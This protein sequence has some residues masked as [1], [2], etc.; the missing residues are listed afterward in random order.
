RIT[1]G[2]AL[3]AMNF[4]ADRMRQIIR[5]FIEP[6]FT[7]FPI[8]RLEL[9]VRSMTQYDETFTIPVLFTPENLSNIFPEV[10]AQAGYRQ[11]RLAETEK[12]AHVTYFF[13]GGN[14]QTFPGE[15]RLLVPSPKVAT[16]DLKPSMSAVEVTD[17]AVQA[18]ESGDYEALIMN[19]ANPDMVGHTGILEAAI[20]ALETID[21]CLA[22]ISEAIEAQGAALFLTSDHGN[23]ETMID[24]ETKEPYTAHTKLPVPFVMVVSDGSLS[25]DKSGKLADIAPTILA[26]LGLEIPEE[27]TGTSRLKGMPAYA[28]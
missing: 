13:N 8:E 26:Y 22:R 25:L 16:Y 17:E 18:I 28:A 11:L 1:S 2:D 20:S 12:Y 27:M 21:Q 10:L 5:A 9:D 4:R 3:L 23:I 7:E 6:D 24:P 19:F 15:A 14:E